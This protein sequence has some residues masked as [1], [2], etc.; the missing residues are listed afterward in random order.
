MFERFDLTQVPMPHDFNF[1]HHLQ[2]LVTK[3]V[4]FR[5]LYFMFSVAIVPFFLE[6]V[7]VF[8]S[9]YLRTAL[10]HRFL[11]HGI[12]RLKFFIS[13][14]PFSDPPPASQSDSGGSSYSLRSIG[15]ILTA[16]FQLQ[17][18]FGLVAVL[19]FR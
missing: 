19:L 7:K 2:D 1:R 17:I 15:R 12:Y 4:I 8:V 3:C 14:T 6:L 11:R 9:I 16:V 10:F 5:Y 13:L 18:T